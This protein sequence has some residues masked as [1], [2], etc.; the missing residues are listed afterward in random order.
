MTTRVPSCL[1]WLCPSSLGRDWLS[2][3]NLNWHQV[4]YHSTL[5][6]N[7]EV[8][9]NTLGTLKGCKAKIYVDSN[10]PPKY[11]RARSVPYSMQTLVE[12][13]L[14]KL[15]KDGV[16][17]P[18][19]HSEWAAPIAPVL[20]SDKSVRICGDFKQT[21]N[22]ASRLDKYPIPRIE[23][24]FAK[25]TGGQRFTKL[26]MSQAYQQLELDEDSKQYVV[27]NTHRGLFRYNRLPYGISSAPGIFQRTMEN[28][29]QGVPHT[30][31][32]LDDILITG[33]T[34]E[35]HLRNLAEVL[36]RLR[37]AGLKLK[38]NKCFFLAKSVV[39]L[40]HTIDADGL[41]PTP[42]K[43]Q[44]VQDA[45]QPTNVSELKSYIGI[46]S[47]YGKFLPNLATTLAPLYTLLHK[48]V[49]WRWTDEEQAAFATSKQLLT[50][51]QVLV[52]FDP[53]KS[54][55]L[56]CDASQYDIGAVLSHRTEDGAEKP[57]G[58]ASRTLS[59]AEKNYSQIEREGLA[60]IFGVK[61]FHSYIYG[62]Q[63]EL[64]TD[65]K[66]LLTLFDAKRSV[67]PQA[68]GRIQRWAL[69]V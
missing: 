22:Q 32:Y 23:D 35:E 46:L 65:H 50:S 64:M 27:I 60:C 53:D 63:F 38:R 24:L 14:D 28:L 2:S 18:V 43:L 4:Y 47:Y 30:V 8:F 51:S 34:E 62:R 19:Q 61:R 5:D 26:D 12:Q 10:V 57:I 31:V 68:S 36:K 69:H 56:S 16:I 11:C 48:D 44:A 37:E 67:S 1:L 29:L 7:S 58:F 20:K 41:H 25:L 54:L 40:G 39:Y 45:P 21:V 49:P 42:D 33:R 55:I 17:E 3:L 59:A 6:Q 13:Q 66:P 15:E 52:H 9:D